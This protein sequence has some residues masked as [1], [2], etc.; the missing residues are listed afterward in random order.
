VTHTGHPSKWRVVNVTAAAVGPA[1][2]SSTT[3]PSHYAKGAAGTI[4]F[5]DRR[6]G[7][8]HADREHWNRSI[9]FRTAAGSNFGSKTTGAAEVNLKRHPNECG[10]VHHWKH[11]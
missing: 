1:W 11:A 3:K 7:D 10:G 2:R 4:S 9:A 6:C 5:N 8:M